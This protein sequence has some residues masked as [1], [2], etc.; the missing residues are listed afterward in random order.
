M[1]VGTRVIHDGME[2]EI[3][4]KAGDVLILSDKTVVRSEDVQLSRLDDSHSGAEER[5]PISP[6]LE[7]VQAG[8]KVALR[9]MIEV[10][11]DDMPAKI[12]FDIVGDVDASM[13]ILPSITNDVERLRSTLLQKAL[14]S[15]KIDP[16]VCETCSQIIP[17]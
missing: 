14:K 3:V 4:E 2:K 15:G 13:V 17:E 1:E 9:N 7:A 10:I 5:E 8:E 6:E 11:T 16:K 12:L